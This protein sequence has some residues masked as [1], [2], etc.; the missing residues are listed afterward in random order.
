MILPS[1]N[2]FYPWL[3][4]TVHS[5]D[6]LISLTTCVFFVNPHYA[7]CSPIISLW[8]F[9]HA[10]PI[11]VTRNDP[12]ADDYNPISRS[13]LPTVC[14]YLYFVFHYCLTLILSDCLNF[15]YLSNLNPLIQKI[16]SLIFII[17][18]SQLI[19]IGLCLEHLWFYL[20]SIFLH[21]SNSLDILAHGVNDRDWTN[22]NLLWD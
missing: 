2:S 1:R 3:L 7:V 10:T 20:T 4:L 14:R 21:V 16:P 6:S 9:L 22:R 5:L 15:T 8:I 13:E 18:N 12:Y 11:H 17:S 19:C